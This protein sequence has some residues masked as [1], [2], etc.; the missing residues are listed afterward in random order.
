MRMMWEPKTPRTSYLVV[1]IG[2]G[3]DAWRRYIEY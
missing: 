3:N 2:S 1:A